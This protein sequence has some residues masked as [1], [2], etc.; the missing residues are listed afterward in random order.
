MTTAVQTIWL[1]HVN[2]A[3][4][5]ACL[6]YLVAEIETGRWTPDFQLLSDI[7]DYME[8]FPEKMHHPKEESYICAALRRRKP[9]AAPLLEK[10]HEEHE[11]GAGMLVDLRARL[12][13][14]EDDPDA[15]AG[16]R[17]ACGEFIAFERH[18]M[19]REERELLPL[20]AQ[21]LLDQDWAEI[22]EAFE[23]NQDPLFGAARRKQ[24]ETLFQHILNQAPS[25]MGFAEPDATP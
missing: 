9:D 17:E 25:P 24:F 22:D 23:Q 15:F 1:E 19:A 3:G 14:Y 2:I 16:F 8:D 11:K 10:I 4:V 12:E 5:L 13:A 18:H 7:L 20:A 21:A 6:R